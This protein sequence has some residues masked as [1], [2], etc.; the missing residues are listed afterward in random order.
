MRTFI[1]IELPEDV[2]ERLSQLQDK[3]GA[4]EKAVRW[5]RPAQI[6]LT[7]KFLGEVPNGQVAAVCEAARE[8][9][10]ACQPFELSVK[11]MGCF[12]PGG[13]PRVLWAGLETLPEPLVECH[14]L[15][16]QGCARLG[17]P[18]ENRPFRP[19]LTLGRVKDTGVSR[20]I[21][22]TIEEFA[23]FDGGVFD[24]EEL[25]VFES[26]LGPKGPAYIPL[27]TLRFGQ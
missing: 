12:P 25:I 18:P 1:A 5:T 15:L 17:F 19:H 14:R 2:H 8:A 21:R 24:A 13:L 3:L 20:A 6:H 27:E 26:R 9:A 16:E 4:I 22:R 7:V 10:I 23:D 11:G